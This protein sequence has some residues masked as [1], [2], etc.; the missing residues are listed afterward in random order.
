MND[1]IQGSYP[2]PVAKAFGEAARERDLASATGLVNA[3]L[4][5]VGLTTMAQLLASGGVPPA[6]HA[7]AIRLLERPL[8]GEWVEFIGNGEKEL[9]ARG[10]RFLLGVSLGSVP[11]RHEKSVALRAS[12][13]GDP[14]GKLTIREILALYVQFRNKHS[15]NKM[16]RERAE[17]LAKSLL[18]SVDELLQQLPSLTSESLRLAREVR[19][20]DAQRVR[21]SFFRLHSDGPPRPDGDPVF[22]T[23]KGH[24]VEGRLFLGATSELVPLYPLMVAVG[25]SLCWINGRAFHDLA[26][27]KRTEPEAALKALGDLIT[28]WRG[29]DGAKE[30]EPPPP[31]SPPADL[32]SYLTAKVLGERL[33]ERLTPVGANLL[34]QNMKRGTLDG[35]ISAQ[36]V[37]TLLGD[38]GLV[39]GAAD[40]LSISPSAAH[41]AV[42]TNSAFP[43][44]GSTRVIRWRPEVLDLLHGEVV[45]RL[46]KKAMVEIERARV[47]DYDEVG[48]MTGSR[49][50]SLQLSEYIVEV[51][52]LAKSTVTRR[53]RES[54]GMHV[55]N[56]FD[57]CYDSVEA[58]GHLTA[59]RALELNLVGPLSELTRRSAKA[60][61]QRLRGAGP[62]TTIRGLFSAE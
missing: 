43:R 50:L 5:Y 57:D 31:P 41:L 42:E 36:M 27:H 35:A 14:A 4:H 9:A 53:L 44:D 54:G 25:E 49:A 21:V 23:N 16:P 19:M 62:R 48:G 22:F 26:G 24:F 61:D 52:G 38:L 59:H 58:L 1:I 32:S 15:H 55:R 2:S 46:G 28:T 29:S 30:P 45:R 33:V 56:I 20:P 3:L 47:P 37:N 51:T 10:R 60:V 7:L 11:A 8:L 40:G 39:V 34:R 17:E 12:L 6:Q 13:E 18:E